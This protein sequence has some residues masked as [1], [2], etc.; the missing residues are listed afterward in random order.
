MPTSTAVWREAVDS[1]LSAK[2]GKID[3]DALND[4]SRSLFEN[5]TVDELREMEHLTCPPPQG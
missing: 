2:R 3:P 5:L 4:T 1:A